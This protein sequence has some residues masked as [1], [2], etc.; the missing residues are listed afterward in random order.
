MGVLIYFICIICI[1]AMVYF[2]R[3]KT[4]QYLLTTLFIIVQLVFNYLLFFEKDFFTSIFFRPDALSSIFIT[5]LTITGITTLINSFVYFSKRNEHAIHRSIYLSSLFMLFACIN[6]AFLSDN[7]NILWI[8]AEA[9]TLCIS[10]LIYHERHEE[11]LEATWKYFFVSTIGLSFSFIGILL[12]NTATNVS[13]FSSLTFSALMSQQIQITNELLFQISFML[14][15][16]GFSVKMGVFPLHTVCIDAHSVAPG[17]V[18]AIISTSLMNVGFVSVFRFFMLFSHTN[19]Y[20]WINHVMLIIGVL[21][22]LFATV[23]MLKVDNYKR[24]IAYSSIEHMGLIS[25]GIAAGGIAYYAVI[26][27]LII[28]SLTKSSLFY[29][30]SQFVGIYRSKHI[31][32]T[33]GY[34]NISP[35]GGILV[36]LL[37]LVIMGIPPSGLF[38]TKFMI[39]QSLIASGYLWLVVIILILLV[40]I[41]WGF[42]KNILHILF[43]KEPKEVEERK[44]KINPWENVPQFILLGLALYIGINPP[45]FLIN[46][47]NEAIQYLP[48]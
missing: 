48:K 17:P 35:S 10:L 15:V 29:Q 38:F 34:F 39:F 3:S 43:L 11:S 16:I 21:S 33:G 19:L 18:S 37:F 47:I 13:G 25:I 44:P 22:L 20:I 6:G 4:M 2:T 23:Y 26:F 41:L 1:A 7:I 42:G 40:F 5:I 30:T 28:H 12:L 31:D 45:D 9:T 36:L 8:L 32:D 46:I 27:H 14:I 24:L